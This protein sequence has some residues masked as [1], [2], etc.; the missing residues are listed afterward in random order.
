MKITKNDKVYVACILDNFGNLGYRTLPTGTKQ[1]TIQMFGKKPTIM[2]W[3]AEITDTTAIEISKMSTRHVCTEHCPE[4]HGPTEF[5][6]M[7]WQVTGMK[8]TIVL[9]NVIPFMRQKK[10]EA[11]TVMEFGLTAPYK[12]AYVEW[13]ASA[14]WDIPNIDPTNTT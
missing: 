1:P 4:P 12:E 5:T 11:Q 3:L 2:G 14:G 13:M 9:H 8:A 10:A 7:R 6:S